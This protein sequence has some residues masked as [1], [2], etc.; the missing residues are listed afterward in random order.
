MK[1]AIWNIV[2]ILGGAVL[3]M[4]WN[5]TVAILDPY[6]LPLG[7]GLGWASRGICNEAVNALGVKIIA[8]AFG[9][10]AALELLAKGVT[11]MGDR[12]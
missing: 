6:A 4:R 8:S 1:R 5:A 3:A 11:K 9:K 7:I 2:L 10:K 12:P